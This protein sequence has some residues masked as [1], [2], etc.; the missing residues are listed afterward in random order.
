MTLTSLHQL[1][2]ATMPTWRRRH[3]LHVES[4]PRRVK[5]VLMAKCSIT[6]THLMVSGECILLFTDIYEN[7]VG[8]VLLCSNVQLQA[9]R[10]LH[11]VGHSQQFGIQ[12]L[13]FLPV[14]PKS[15]FCRSQFFSP[16]KQWLLTHLK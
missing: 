4:M 10:W 14:F 3:L 6:K 7:V 8:A 15:F 11:P 12:R 5:A 1:C 2:N 13:C 16:I 9:V